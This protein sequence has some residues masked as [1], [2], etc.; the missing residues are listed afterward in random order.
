MIRSSAVAY[1]LDDDAYSNAYFEREIKKPIR[2]SGV[3][4]RTGDAADVVEASDGVEEIEEQS[5]VLVLPVTELQNDEFKI[6]LREPIP[7]YFEG[8][9]TDYIAFHEESRVVGEGEDLSAAFSDFSNAFITVYLSYVQST[10]SLS[11]GAEE[12]ARYL[13]NL[14]QNIEE[15]HNRRV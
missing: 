8:Q 4:G 15:L 13:R 5:F 14:V 2:F 9:E 12:F 1:A 6:V 7:I 3:P 10:D 11:S